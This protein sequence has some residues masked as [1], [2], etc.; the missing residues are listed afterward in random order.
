MRFVSLAFLSICAIFMHSCEHEAITYADVSDDKTIKTS[1]YVGE[2]RAIKLPINL[3]SNKDISIVGDETFAKTS[4]YWGNDVYPILQA[5]GLKEGRQKLRV[6]AYAQDSSAKQVDLELV[7]VDRGD[8]D[9]INGGGG[10]G[11]TDPDPDPDKPPKP[12][13]GGPEQDPLACVNTPDF[14][15]VSDDWRDTEG[16]YGDDFG[17]RIQSKIII[18]T[19]STVTLYYPKMTYSKRPPDTVAL[20]TYLF[21]TV[22]GKVLSYQVDLAQELFGTH[23]IKH[24][25]VKTNGYC[26]RSEI[27]T[28]FM[29]PPNKKV[30]WVSR[31]GT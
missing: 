12:P 15:I 29:S 1:L 11:G 16:K 23:K 31:A 21:T 20:G 14:K 3:K 22:T 8:L 5:K 19:D 17:G 7:V 10:G 9:I 13:D 18:N 24:F 2:Q 25:Y 26:L 4:M 28:S 6:V 30:V 27:P